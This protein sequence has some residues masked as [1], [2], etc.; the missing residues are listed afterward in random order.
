MKRDLETFPS[1]VSRLFTPQQLKGLNRLGDFYCPGDELMPAFSASGAAEGIDRLATAMH[2]RDLADFRLL[3]TLAARLP[4]PLLA[5]LVNLL[6]QADRLGPWAKDLRMA[7]LGA[8][9][10]A[11]SLYY[12]FAGSGGPRVRAAIGWDAAIRSSISGEPAMNQLVRDAAPDLSPTAAT[13]EDAFQRAHSAQVTIAALIIEQRLAVL[14]RLGEVILRRR[15]EI[16]ARVSQETGKCA[17]D[18]LLGEIFATLDNLEY[19]RKNAR[20][21]LSDRKVATPLA[22]LGKKSRVWYEPLGTILVIAPWNYPFYQ[23]IVPISIAFAAGNAVIHK[24]SEFT[25]LTGLIESILQEAGFARDW[26]QVVYG[27]GKAGAHCLAQRP[28]KV[29]FTGSIATGK[30]VMAQAA[31]LLVPVELELGGKDAMILFADANLDRA[32]AGAMWGALTNTGQSCTSI[33]RLY[34]ERSVFD[35]FTVKLVEKVQAL[36]LGTGRDD[37][38]GQM[39]TAAQVAIIRHQLEDALAKGARQ[40]TGHSWDRQSPQIPPI[41]LTQVDHSMLV[42]E[43]ESF[44][45]FLPLMPFEGDD[46]A[47]SLANRTIYGLSA[48]VW[49]GDIAR[50]QRVAR[51]LHVGNVSINNHMITEGNHGL[52]FGGAK[53]SGI[54]RF[55]GEEGLRG[56][57]NIKAVMIDGNSSKIEANWYPFTEAKYAAMDKMTVASR[58]RGLGGLVR[59]ALA[60]LP[61]ESLANKLGRKGRK[62]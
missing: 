32:V 36:Q 31:E 52:P 50:A 45:P 41:V 58:M 30:K 44:G 8:A 38:I 3:L 59:F 40:L 18:A 23:A 53:Q 37:D 20:K 14:D 15:D 29:F 9:G 4:Q 49:S 47:V 19:L 62:G 25:P 17:T 42:M 48:C 34:I 55:K 57:C 13:V 16:I 26:A 7:R 1:P 6:D 56:F 35:S 24:P 51:R 43:E 22:M 54:G 11:Y 2:P 46:H 39:T 12:G 28:D 10:V 21:L 33:E 27:D 5:S 60:G 61:L